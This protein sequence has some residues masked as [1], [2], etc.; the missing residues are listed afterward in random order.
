MAWWGLLGHC[1]HISDSAYP[2]SVLEVVET[3]PDAHVHEVTDAI[4]V[5]F[6]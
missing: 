1:E 4:P 3:I 5:E 6:C 2:K